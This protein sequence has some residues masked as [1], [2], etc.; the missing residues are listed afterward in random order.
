VPLV[1][2]AAPVLKAMGRRGCLD[3]RHIDRRRFPQS[4]GH[5]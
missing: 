4:A 1:D 3:W 2:A 5:V